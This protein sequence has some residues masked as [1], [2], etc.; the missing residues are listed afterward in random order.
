M[1]IN[2]RSI[3]STIIILVIVGMQVKEQIDFNRRGSDLPSATWTKL[4]PG[5]D[6]SGWRAESGTW[7]VEGGVLHPTGA[8]GLDSAVLLCERQFGQHFEIRG[9]LV[10]KDANELAVILNSHGLGKRGGGYTDVIFR[11]SQQMLEM[12]KKGLDRKEQ[13][14]ERLTYKGETDFLI[15]WWKDYMWVYIGGNLVANEIAVQP[16]SVGGKWYYGK[17]YLGVAVVGG[18]GGFKD[19]EVRRLTAE[20]LVTTVKVEGPQGPLPSMDLSP[21]AWTS[22]MPPADMTGWMEAYGKWQIDTSGLLR[23]GKSATRDSFLLLRRAQF[24]SRLEVRGNLTGA[25]GLC[26]LAVVLNCPDPTSQDIWAAEYTG[27]VFEPGNGEVGMADQGVGNESDLANRVPFT[28]KSQFLVQR[29]DDKVWVYVD[30]KLVAREVP[31]VPCSMK[32]KQFLGVAMMG[33]G[34]FR[35]LEIRRL[36]KRPI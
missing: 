20:P 8:Q 25:S 30:G 23:H 27:I 18:S 16:C 31:M 26:R 29:W 17:Q 22:F 36:D 12:G 35:N 7:T 28:D 19:L 5:A 13:L 34:G 14:G 15:Q 1:R 4:M 10:G 33:E 2:L 3:L 32:G 21:T 24:G 9:K 6:L 11:P